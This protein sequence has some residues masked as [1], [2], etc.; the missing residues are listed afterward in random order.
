MDNQD[1]QAQIKKAIFD[2]EVEFTRYGILA[3]ILFSVL[4]VA[5]NFLIIYIIKNT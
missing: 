3:A 1:I 2:H 5:N 4:L